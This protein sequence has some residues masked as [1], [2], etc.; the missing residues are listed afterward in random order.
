M[1]ETGSHQIS[2]QKKKKNVFP[3]HVCPPPL[4]VQDSLPLFY[5]WVLLRNRSW[6]LRWQNLFC[7]DLV[8]TLLQNLSQTQGQ[9]PNS[10][11]PCP[12]PFP[13]GHS[14]PLPFP[15]FCTQDPI[16]LWPHS[17]SC[18]FSFF[19]QDPVQV[20]PRLQSLLKYRVHSSVGT[21]NTWYVL[22]CQHLVKKNG[23]KHNVWILTAPKF[24]HLYKP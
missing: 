5:W 12:T 4:H 13:S 23:E 14:P 8:L 7:L 6:P 17:G 22:V 3:R 2:L 16:M 18:N 11:A 1:G 15:N 20:S 24:L 9:S 21:L 19:H 10:L